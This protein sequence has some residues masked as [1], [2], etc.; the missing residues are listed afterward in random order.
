MDLNYFTQKKKD[1]TRL[2]AV[3]AEAMVLQEIAERKLAG[4]LSEGDED[5]ESSQ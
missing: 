1:I 2:R 3:V 4:E 5:E